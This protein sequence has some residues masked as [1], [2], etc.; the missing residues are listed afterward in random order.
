M[1]FG[2]CGPV[3]LLE[4]ANEQGSLIKLPGIE[5]QARSFARQLAQD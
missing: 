2:V 1:R 5:D 3:S 4:T